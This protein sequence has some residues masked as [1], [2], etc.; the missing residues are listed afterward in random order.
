MAR[1]RWLGTAASVGLLLTTGTGIA[2]AQPATTTAPQVVP[3]GYAYPT[4]AVTPDGTKAYVGV[5]DDPRGTPV[6][7]VVD[8]RTGGITARL[9]L[10]TDA[11]SFVGAL[12][13]SP[14]GTRLYATVGAQ[15]LVT[16]DTDSDTVAAD[17]LLPVQPH[18]DGYVDGSPSSLVV[19]PDGAGVY[20]A[21]NGPRQRWGFQP[22]RVLAYSTTAGAFT[23]SVGVTDFSVGSIVLRPNG[24]DLY[25]TT[26]AG[27]VHLAATPTS[28]TTVRTLT[29]GHGASGGAVL[30]PDGSTLYGLGGYE[31]DYLVDTE[32]DTV[33]ENFHFAPGNTDL[34]Y[35][36]VS[37]DG[38]RLYFI[39]KST[40]FVTPGGPTPPGYHY[41]SVILSYDTEAHALVPAETVNPQKVELATGLALAPDGH[42]FYLG[43][44]TYPGGVPGIVA[45]LEIISN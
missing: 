22:A 5:T 29:A 8:T 25:V 28:L 35:P 32:T 45:S 7:K 3:V 4:T 12:A 20:L 44:N 34:R 19:S 27:L 6:V 37:P 39:S 11:N 24:Q 43:G 13:M 1:A 42:T 17:V 15:H 26:G 30:S 2:T 36:V 14:D 38:S 33:T 16:I 40:V 41:E 31:S 9:T 23:A 21:Q 18:P 10:S